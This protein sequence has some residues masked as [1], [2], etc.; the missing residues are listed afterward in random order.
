MNVKPI[1]EIAQINRYPVKSF[2]GQKLNSVT[3][4]SYGLFGDRSHAFVD[5]TKKGWSRYITA[6]Q[7]PE[8]L[9]YR[10]ECDHELSTHEFPKVK[11]IGPDGRKHEWN[12]RLLEEIQAFT[13]QKIS[14]ERFSLLSQNRL[15]VDD[16][17]I[18]IITDQSL[19]RIEQLW[20]KP[21]D[22]RR[23]RANFIIKLYDDFNNN[24]SFF[25]DKRITIG[26]A[27]LSIQS[28]CE[29]C[30]MITIDPDNLERDTTLLKRVHED[31]NLNFGMYADVVRAGAVQ[32]GDQI[33][34]SERVI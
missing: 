5:T 31:M 2:A 24:D 25:I 8:M 23:F 33:Y 13:D 9:C 30:A 12:D 3:L 29:R 14:M 28:L 19:K 6:R 18:L 17:G 4:E 15:A 11:I 10:A 20:G 1:G 34:L 16:G 21:V 22:S 27:E 32:V 7:I 26:D